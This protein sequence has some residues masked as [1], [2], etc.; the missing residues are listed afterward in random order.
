MGERALAAG[1][2]AEMTK[3]YGELIARCG[4]CHAARRPA[5]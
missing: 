3:V 4:D 1:Q 2:P 5:S